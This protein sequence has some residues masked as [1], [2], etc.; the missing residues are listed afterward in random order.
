MSLVDA[1]PRHWRA[2]RESEMYCPNRRNREQNEWF[3]YTL[4][5][6]GM[7]IRTDK[8]TKKLVHNTLR[9]KQIKAHQQQKRK[10]RI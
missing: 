3:K 8:I 4:N 2:L 6:G 9:D 1:I 7:D 5:I 10:L